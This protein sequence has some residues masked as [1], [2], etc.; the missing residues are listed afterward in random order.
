MGLIYCYGVIEEP[1]SLELKSF[2]SNQVYL[3]NFKDLIAVVS[4]VSDEEFSQESIDENVKNMKWLTTNG[5]M[6]EKII[7][8]FMN[9][10]TIIPMKFCTIFKTKEKVEEMLEEKYADF[11]FNLNELKDKVEMTVKVYFDSTP[12]KKKISN[13]DE[14]IKKLIIEAEKKK[15]GAKYFDEQKI[16]ILLKEKVRNKLGNSTRN[17]FEEIKSLVERG[18][19]NEL[20]D[21]KLTGKDMLLNGVFLILKKDI[22][23]FKKEVDKVKD[24]YSDFEFQVFGGFPPYNF[25]K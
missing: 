4:D 16:D 1:L 21:K 3:I 13:E 2:E 23:K 15:P 9:K 25:I 11:K 8:E 7:D 5:Q 10:T 22:E 12:L 14:E 19:Q 24:S 17:I 18:K 6:H 20:I